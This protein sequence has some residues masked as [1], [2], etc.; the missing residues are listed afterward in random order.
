MGQT[1]A[2]TGEE[3][4][5]GYATGVI[6]AAGHGDTTMHASNSSCYAKSPKPKQMLMDDDDNDTNA[7]PLTLSNNSKFA[8]EYQDRKSRQELK[9]WQQESRNSGYGS[10]ADSDSDQSDEDENATQLTTRLD[11]SIFETMTAIR[12]K[13]ER[14]YDSKIRFFDDK[15][16]SDGDDKPTGVEGEPAHTKKRFKDVVREQILDQMDREEKGLPVTNADEDKYEPTFRASDVASSEKLA[17]NEEQ[18]EIRKAFQTHDDADPEEDGDLFMTKTRDKSAKNEEV[19]EDERRRLQELDRCLKNTTADNGAAP[20]SSAVDPR[21]DV[22]DGEGFLYDFLRNKRWIDPLAE[23]DNDNDD[24]DEE[25]EEVP[26]KGPKLLDDDDDDSLDELDKTD[27]FESKYNFRF[28]EQDANSNTNSAN[29]EI[30]GYARGQAAT[31]LRK[32]DEKR[33]LARD[34]KRERKAA[35]RRAKEEK[36]RRLKN[37]KR[38]ELDRKMVLIREVAGWGNSGGDPEKEAAM[39]GGIDE[40][41]MARL[42]QEDFDPEVFG[43][44]MEENVYNDEFYKQ[45]ED[46]WTKDAHVTDSLKGAKDAGVEEG[47]YDEPESHEQNYDEP[48][49][50]SEEAEPEQTVA[51]A[52]TQ[53]QKR[54]EEELY[55]LD[56]EDLIG[57]MPCRFKYRTVTANSYGL[58]TREIL[59]SS[60]ATLKQ[61]VSLK[62]MAPYNEDHDMGEYTVG[63]KKRKRFRDA[64]KEELLLREQEQE[65]HEK[66]TEEPELDTATATDEPKKRRRK[67]KGV[68]KQKGSVDDKDTTVP[69]GSGD[70][71]TSPS[72][73]QSMP[74]AETE[75]DTTTAVEKIQKTVPDTKRTKK[76][77]ASHSSTKRNSTKKHTKKKKDGDICSASRLASYGL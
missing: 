29:H 18:R 17:Y 63:S 62:K 9:T 64:L 74:K 59:L 39:A 30:V 21:G 45:S 49:D 26:M 11:T 3:Y 10:D 54:M 12:N 52:E 75:G 16:D 57:D 27:D 38:A 24:S 15:E 2:A 43:K 8:K 56:Y 46:E 47:L 22:K 19:E 1:A 55:K 53:I 23:N 28:E 67:K 68:K 20:P 25:E 4:R 76:K 37:A 70:A 65:P 73:P 33:K 61:F 40:E 77:R 42:I 13:D 6:S 60:D 5:C 7:P 44:A 50:E 48:Y 66:G 36:L 72:K 14:V 32:P 31:T 35:E 69:E 34:A 51:P 41:T 71:P 58:D